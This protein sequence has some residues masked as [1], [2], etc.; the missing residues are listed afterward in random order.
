MLSN[1]ITRVT[2][3]AAAAALATLGL[4]ACDDEEVDVDAFPERNIEIYVGFG[5]GGGSDLFAR[6][7]QQGIEDLHDVSVQVVNMEGAGGANAIR[8]VHS[9]AADGHTWYADYSFAVLAGQ[10]DLGEDGDEM[11]KPVARFQDEISHLMVMPDRFESWED[12]EAE[13]QEETIRL[14]GVGTAGFA[15]FISR[16]FT[17]ESGLNITYVPFGN[18]GEQLAALQSGNIDAAMEELAAALDYIDSGEIISIMAMNDER[19]DEYPDIP[20]SVEMGIDV[21]TGA[22]RGIMV[23]GETDDELIDIIEEMLE[24]VYESEDYKEFEAFSLLDHRPGWMGRDEYTEYTN[25]IIDV[26]RDLEAGD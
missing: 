18:A 5:A 21:T 1:K 17:A 7:V 12:F 9:Q 23:H 13:G 20:A 2:G 8:E 6:Q 25:E 10:G 19:L 24:E 4:T 22:S 15:E 11:F 26:T 14:G 16:E 3:I